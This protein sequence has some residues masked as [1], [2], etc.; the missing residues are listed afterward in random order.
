MIQEIKILNTYKEI[1][2]ILENLKKAQNALEVMELYI[3]YLK[4]MVKLS[5]NYPEFCKNPK[6]FKYGNCYTYALDFKCPNDF[7]LKYKSYDRWGMNFD[8]GFITTYNKMGVKNNSEVMLLD[9]FYRDMEALNIKVIDSDINDLPKHNGYQIFMYKDL[10]IASNYDFHFVRL[11]SDMILSHRN[12]YNG[13]INA[14][15]NL[16]KVPPKY[17]LVKVFEIVKPVIRE[18]IL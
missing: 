5:T 1:L 14:L 8:V 3:E 17:K 13:F 4:Q 10:N 11:N 16:S 7:W 6:E 15:P 18:R 2:T 12:G 9:N